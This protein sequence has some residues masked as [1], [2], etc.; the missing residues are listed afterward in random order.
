MNSQEILTKSDYS[1]SLVFKKP[2]IF[3]HCPMKVLQ[4]PR[5]TVINLNARN[6]GKFGHF[7]REVVTYRGIAAA[8]KSERTSSNAA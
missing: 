7:Q 2:G 6:P 8:G 3:G 4:F 5:E 1:M